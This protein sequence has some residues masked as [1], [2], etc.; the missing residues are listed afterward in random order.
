MGMGGKPVLHQRIVTDTVIVSSRMGNV[1]QHGEESTEMVD[2]IIEFLSGDEVFYAFV[3][4]CLLN[5]FF[6]IIRAM[7]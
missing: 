5:I 2:K 6:Q 4:F 7:I 3:I 1:V